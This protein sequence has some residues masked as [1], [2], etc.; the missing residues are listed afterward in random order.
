MR[1]VFSIRVITSKTFEIFIQSA[2]IFERL[3]EVLRCFSQL[4]WSVS[5]EADQG[6]TLNFNNNKKKK[7]LKNKKDTDK[8]I[9][10]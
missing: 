1:W 4:R 3:K 6:I 8:I 5:L 9:W 7:N 2:T 10:N